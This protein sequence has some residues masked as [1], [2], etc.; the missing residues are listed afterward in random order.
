MIKLRLNSASSL[1]FVTIENGAT[2]A[3]VKIDTS[4][5]AIGIFALELESFDSA[6]SAPQAT[7]KRD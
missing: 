4:A 7:L 3:N 5:V 1:P 6:A 2:S